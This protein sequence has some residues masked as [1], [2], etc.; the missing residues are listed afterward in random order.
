MR[1]V[2]VF[3]HRDFPMATWRGIDDHQDTHSVWETSGLI[4]LFISASESSTYSSSHKMNGVQCA[5]RLGVYPSSICACITF[6][7]FPLILITTS[8]GG[9]L[10]QQFNPYWTTDVL[11]FNVLD[12]D[13]NTWEIGPMDGISLSDIHM[14]L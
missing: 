4:I 8:G 11:I 1:G 12:M 5:L 9:H 10:W 14:D 3:V 6:L 13:R 7:L 2:N